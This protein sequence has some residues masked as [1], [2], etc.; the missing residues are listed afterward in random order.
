MQLLIKL[1]NYTAPVVNKQKLTKV[2]GTGEAEVLTVAFPTPHLTIP[3]VTGLVTANENY[4]VYAESV[5]KTGFD[6]IFRKYDGT[7][8]A[9]E[10]LNVYYRTEDS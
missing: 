10:T 6:I 3:I 7:K 2:A 4:K 9:G 8:F 5:T 1:K